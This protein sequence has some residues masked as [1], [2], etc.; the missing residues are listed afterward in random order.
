MSVHVRLGP[1][2][3]IFL[4]LDKDWVKI[5]SFSFVAYWLYAIFRFIVV[6]RIYHFITNSSG[7]REVG[8]RIRL[9]NIIPYAVLFLIL[10]QIL[11]I[12]LNNRLLAKSTFVGF[13]IS[14]L[15]FL[16]FPLFFPVA[17]DLRGLL[18]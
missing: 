10:G 2:N 8:I 1:A 18:I 4:F 11:G 9:S 13:L 15:V 17:P 14:V 3:R 16:N 7:I 6:L 12:I 5:I